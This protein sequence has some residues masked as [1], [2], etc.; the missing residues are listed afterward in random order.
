MFLNRNHFYCDGDGCT[1]R[2]YKNAE[3]VY[4][5]K[6]TFERKG[7][8]TPYY[9][10]DLDTVK[11]IEIV[12]NKIIGSYSTFIRFYRN[13]IEKA[14]IDSNG[15]ENSSLIY[16]VNE[17]N[18]WYP[19]LKYI[20]T[21]HQCPRFDFASSFSNIFNKCVYEDGHI[22][23]IYEDNKLRSVICTSNQTHK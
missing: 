23:L 6:N 1:I 10:I 5:T 7:T 2:T 3:D 9:P 12:E 13:Y 21:S 14:I 20:K 22:A 17:D 8:G 16:I 18:F 11:R 19:N 4:I 15:I